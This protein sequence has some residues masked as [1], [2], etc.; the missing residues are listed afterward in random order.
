M[1]SASFTFTFASTVL[2]FLLLYPLSSLAAERTVFEARKIVTM[3]PSMPEARF[4]VVETGRILSVGNSLLELETWLDGVDYSIDSQF[5]DK[6]LL[7]GLIDPHLHPMMAAVLLPT[8]F[9]TPED[10]SL[11]SGEALG[12]RS[13]EAYRQ[14]LREL[15]AG[16]QSTDP[17]ITWG[18]HQLWHGELDRKLLDEIEPNRAV[19][20][21]HRSFHEIILNTAAM[22]FLQLGSEAEFTERLSASG[23]DPSH[24]NYA[25]GLLSETALGIG[26]AG[27]RPVILAP[28]H[29]NAG[30]EIIQQMLRA[31]GVTTIADMATGLFAGFNTEAALIRQTFDR[32]D[33]PV[34]VVMVP[35]AKPLAG[36][37]GSAEAAVEFLNEMQ[38]SQ[39]SEKVFLNNRV[40][41]LAD[42]AFFSQ[43]MRMNPPGY[44][45]G[46]EGKWLTEPDELESLTRVFWNAG[47]HIHTHVNGDEGLDAVLNVLEKLQIEKPL[48]DHR[49]TLEHFGYS[50]TAQARRVQALGALVSAQP[51]YIYVLSDNYA[52]NGLGYD[53][54][55]QIVRLGTLERQGTVVALHSDLT[56][57][58]AD[59]LFL[60]WI[61]TNRV[62]MEGNVMGANER[63]SVD[64][65]LRAM[66]ID[67]AFVIGLEEEIGSISAG[68]KADFAVLEQ[69]PYEVDV[70]DLR[71]IPI[72]GVVFEGE[73]FAANDQL[74]E[75]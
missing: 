28:D 34:R 38:L 16:D 7:P 52:T 42:G 15:I 64:K 32:E 70:M 66:T 8:A 27:L 9:I 35:N 43:Y 30:M 54:A 60:A 22:R 61:A 40:K 18:Y 45:D 67:A 29:L 11:P 51:N 1:K 44:S 49:F 4:V 69:D 48:P 36:Q 75:Q 46:H 74:I 13:P 14:R 62:T 5:R 68:K 3:D 72:W 24:A 71:N 23:I 53:R 57:A 31:N 55:S 20:I 21:W 17:F 41:F 63:L 33:S 25:A 19:V 12:V 47:F 39:T 73:A 65:A 58:P 6:V 56:M 2:G 37:L 50:T 10:W 59:P 26:L